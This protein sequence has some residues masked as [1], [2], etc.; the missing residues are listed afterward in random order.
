MDDVP[1]V[2]GRHE[3][4]DLSHET[5]RRGRHEER[6]DVRGIVNCGSCA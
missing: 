5:G 1:R 3:V 6:P 4:K 2:A